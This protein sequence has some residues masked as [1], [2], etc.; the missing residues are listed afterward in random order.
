VGVTGIAFDPRGGVMWFN[1]FWA[2][3]VARLTRR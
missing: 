1:E 3:K 2:K